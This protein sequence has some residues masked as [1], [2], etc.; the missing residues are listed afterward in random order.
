M[1]TDDGTT[2]WVSAQKARWPS[3]DGRWHICFDEH[4]VHEV[5]CVFEPPNS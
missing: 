2:L 4:E 3:R 1:T 5:L